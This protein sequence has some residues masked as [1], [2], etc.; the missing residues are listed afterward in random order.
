MTH[1]YRVFFIMGFLYLIDLEH[2]SELD[3][4]LESEHDSELESEA[5][6]VV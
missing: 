3:S 5:P 4:E 2:D 1:N 6:Y